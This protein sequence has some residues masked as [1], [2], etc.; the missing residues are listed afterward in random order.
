MKLVQ[1]QGKLARL[2][3]F[4]AACCMDG[5]F[6]LEAATGYIS[7]ALGYHQLTE[8]NPYPALCQHIEALAQR[9]GATLPQNAG[10]TVEVTAD[11][12]Q[13]LDELGEKFVALQAERDALLQQQKLCS[14]GIVQY[15]HF[16]TLRAN[17]DE[18]TSCQHVVVRF[19]FLPKT[20]AR[21][22]NECYADYPYLL[23]V[24]CTEAADGVWGVYLTP[25]SKAEEADG[26]FSM[27][28]FEP[29]QVPGAAG[30][31]AQIM[32][33][34]Q[35][36]MDLVEKELAA[37]DSRVHTLWQE[38]E[39]KLLGLYNTVR[40]KAAA[41]DLRQYAAVSGDNFVCVGWVPA[42]D[43]KEI[44]ARAEKIADLRVTVDE[45][46][47]A[48]GHTPPTRLR[49]AWW[50]RPFQFFVEMYGLP[51]YGETDVTAFV[52][53]TFTVLFGI[54]FGDLGQGIVLALFSTYMWKVKHNALFHLMIPCGISSAVF[55]LVYGS[56]F[57]F[58][59]ALDPLY[60]AIGLAGKPVS[61]MDSINSILLVAVFIGVVLV[62]AA[63]CLHMY[64]A[65]RRGHW[66][67]VIFSTNGL[68]GMAAYLGGVS[69]CS[70]FMGG[71]NLL[72]GGVSTVLVAGGLVVLLFEGVLAPM[73]N[74]EPWKPKEGWGGYLM[75]S[76]FELL[77]SVL[78][79]LSNTISF[80]RVGAFVIVHASMMLVVFT[81]A[82]EPANPVVVVL[83]NIVVI[84]LEALLSAIQGIRLEFYEMFSRCYQG[85]GR[86]YEALDLTGQSRESRKAA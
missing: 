15:S 50:S 42:R 72:P 82:G 49:N 46:E 20:G 32:E 43:V 45:P 4:L 53:L 80:L 54:M 9:C 39:E 57:G 61:V 51:S 12:Q 55:G 28:L 65:A 2:D 77:E 26:I 33:H 23:F 25:R 3:E 29:L 37:L 68:V 18:I 58:E 66:G 19:G 30:T 14:D 8:E 11:S 6:A 56:V 79:Y 10:K 27:L 78:S 47:L 85:G 62:L 41:A 44:T 52:A 40:Y 48:G 64:T 63:M 76:V 1:V 71:P 74:G 38:N 60:H 81:L 73:V 13:Y 7:A 35:E 70:A 17:M 36:D 31:P 84:C 5:R 59:E 69:L 83:G 34:F 21:K 22:L 24:P 86:K 67:D 75:Q 16:A